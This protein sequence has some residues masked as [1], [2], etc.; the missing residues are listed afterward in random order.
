MRAA[1]ATLAWRWRGYLCTG[2]A[3]AS[4]C[5]PHVARGD[6]EDLARL[7]AR[8]AQVQQRLEQ[9]REERDE[10]REGLRDVER[11]IGAISHD[12]KLLRERLSAVERARTALE[13]RQQQ[14]RTRLQVQQRQWREHI[15]AAYIA[16]GGETSAIKILLNHDNPATLQRMWVY[17]GYIARARTQNIS[18][19]RAAAQELNA[20]HAQLLERTRELRD[21]LA[22][23]AREKTA[24]QQLLTRRRTLL[25]ELNRRIE[26]HSVRLDRLRRDEQRLTRLVEEVGRT[27]AA[28]PF[29]SGR[30]MRFAQAKGRLPLPLA[31]TLQARFG[32]PRLGTEVKW[33]GIFLAA[34]AGADV[35]AIFPGRVAYADWLRG[36][37]LL[38]IVEHDDGYMSLYGHGQS[39][40]KKVGDAVAAGE[41]IGSAGQ[42]GGFSAPGLYF[43]IRHRGQPRNPLEWCRR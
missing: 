10:V 38:L 1:L 22:R 27:V 29:P 3:L 7:R 40:Y 26:S 33:Q 31:G 5:V 28:V 11:D 43:E 30:G 39:L 21:L 24:L 12:L 37:G 41:V 34:P 20:G 18:A 14:Q 23:Q 6:D 4:L 8:I 9:T 32:A 15:R 16:R 2:I 19:L 42:T 13:R 25:T 35:K 17:H 36:F